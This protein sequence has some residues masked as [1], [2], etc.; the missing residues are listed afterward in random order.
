MGMLKFREDLL[1]IP[2]VVDI[3][4]LPLP[5]LFDPQTPMTVRFSFSM[6]ETLNGSDVLLT[7]ST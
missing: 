4:V 3:G 6:T 1:E 7:T 5:W 2:F